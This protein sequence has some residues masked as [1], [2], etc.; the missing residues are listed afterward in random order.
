MI[1]R[2]CFCIMMGKKDVYP[3]I[4]SFIHLS[5]IRLPLVPSGF[6]QARDGQGCHSEPLVVG[7]LEQ[8][9]LRAAPSSMVALAYG[10]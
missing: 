7:H 2:I 9:Y 3:F 6:T 10:Y 8:Q 1:K 4:I 5:D